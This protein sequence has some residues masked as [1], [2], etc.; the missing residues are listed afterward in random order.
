MPAKFSFEK[1]GFSSLLSKINNSE[2]INKN[3]Y[4]YIYIYLI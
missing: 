3:V 4:I 1:L 2:I